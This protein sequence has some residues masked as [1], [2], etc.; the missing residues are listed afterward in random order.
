[1]RKADVGLQFADTIKLGFSGSNFRQREPA[2]PEYSPN[3]N[4]PP[5]DQGGLSWTFR[6]PAAEMREPP[7]T[8]VA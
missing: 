4:P 5:G 6:V 1:M 2:A 3:K 8:A 7:Q